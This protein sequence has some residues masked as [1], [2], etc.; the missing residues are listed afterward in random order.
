MYSY[1]LGTAEKLNSASRARPW[2]GGGGRDGEAAQPDN[3]I[4]PPLIS[5]YFFIVITY[6]LT[7]IVGTLYYTRQYIYI[8]TP[9]DRLPYIGTH[10]LSHARIVLREWRICAGKLE[11]KREIEKRE[12]YYIGILTQLQIVLMCTCT[13]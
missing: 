6:S 13:R 1:A 9:R 3:P 5:F 4:L 11:R 8:Y 2:R 12:S 10:T 7:F